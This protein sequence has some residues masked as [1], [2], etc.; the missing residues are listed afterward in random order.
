M[1]G[2]IARYP[3]KPIEGGRLRTEKS[4][5]QVVGDHFRDQVCPRVGGKAGTQALPD[6]H[7]EGEYQDGGFRAT[8]NSKASNARPRNG[9]R[10][11]TVIHK[12]TAYTVARR[13]QPAV[14]SWGSCQPMLWIA[15]TRPIS[16]AKSVR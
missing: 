6:Q 11:W 5:Q 10:S 14:S 7:Q 8:G 16:T 9:S 4:P 12:V 15:G 3:G 13:S 1:P 2:V